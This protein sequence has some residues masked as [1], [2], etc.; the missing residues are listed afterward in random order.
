MLSLIVA[1]LQEV[2]AAVERGDAKN[3]AFHTGK[4]GGLAAATGAWISLDDE[5]AEDYNPDYPVYVC[6]VLCDAISSAYEY[7]FLDEI[8]DILLELTGQADEEG[9]YD[10]SLVE[11][12]G[13]AEYGAALNEAVRAK[14]E[15]N[16]LRYALMMGFTSGLMF[17]DSGPRYEDR[18][19]LDAITAAYET[20]S[21]ELLDWARARIGAGV[22]MTD[23]TPF[24][25]K[26]QYD[27]YMAEKLETLRWVQNFGLHRARAD[28]E[29]VAVPGSMA[30]NHAVRHMPSHQPS[31]IP[32]QPIEYCYWVIPGKLLAGEYPRTP[33]EASSRE[34]L[35]R[36]TDA[37]VSAF[38]DLTEFDGRLADRHLEPYAHLLSGQSHE[39]FPI[40]DMSVPASADLTKAALDVIDGHLAAGRTVYVHC[41]G[42]VGRTG[43]II[44]CWLARHGEPGQAALDKLTELWQENPKSRSRRSP[45]TEEQARYVL[46]W[47][48]D[49]D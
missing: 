23:P 17:N 29:S 21:D 5:E 24:M 15:G 3:Y 27:R 13:W 12:I 19:I 44:G 10:D 43:T 14:E 42:G 11:S 47:N 41:W 26:E 46:A 9:E 1:D 49:T 20:E 38:I 7:N 2:F 37:G 30:I 6:R 48:E 40:R 45:E 4:A 35:A 16:E 18:S 32:P 39:R 28:D 36:L 33:D 31:E 22:R 25:G 8:E 34:K